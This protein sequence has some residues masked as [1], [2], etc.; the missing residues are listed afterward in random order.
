MGHWND[1]ELATLKVVQLFHVKL[2]WS[3]VSLTWRLLFLLEVN[4]S[5]NDCETTILHLLLLKVKKKKN[6]AHAY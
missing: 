2:A 6:V 1:L 4:E 3:A 5:L